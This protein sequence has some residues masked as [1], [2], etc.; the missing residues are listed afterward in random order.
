MGYHEVVWCI[1][2][3][4][5]LTEYGLTQLFNKTESTGKLRWPPRPMCPP[6]VILGGGAS[7]RLGLPP[8][9]PLSVKLSLR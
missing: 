3:V 2:N 6:A 1:Q 5:I 7:C 4:W 9:K 8:G